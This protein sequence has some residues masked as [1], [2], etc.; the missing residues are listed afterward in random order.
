MRG[1][2]YAGLLA[3]AGCYEGVSENA[4]DSDLGD[5]PSSDGSGNSEETGDEGPSAVDCDAPQPGP[6]PIRRLS[7]RE[8]DNTLRDLLGPDAALASSML[9]PDVRVRAAARDHAATTAAPVH[10]SA[11][12]RSPSRP[13]WPEGRSTIHSVT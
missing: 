7:R 13:P 9:P 10:T 11:Q 3:L 4:G 12:A 2:A 5:A 1:W 6:T 8:L